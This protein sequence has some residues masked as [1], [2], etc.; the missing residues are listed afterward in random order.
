MRAQTLFAVAAQ[1]ILALSARA[2]TEQQFRA[3]ADYSARHNGHAVIVMID[4]KIVFEQ[5]QNGHTAEQPHN[6][7]SGT[8]TFWGPVLAALIEDGLVSSLDEPVSNT[9]TEWKSDAR[10]RRITIR[11]LTELNAGLIQ[12]VRNLQGEDRPTLAGDL[13]KHAITL[14]TVFEPGARFVYGPSC[15]YALGELIKRKLAA[16]KQ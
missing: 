9:I 15:Y 3:A 16:R 10:K 11:N 5:Y 7:Y 2:Q 6:L 12:D 14:P 1:F 4:G 8:K 13:Y